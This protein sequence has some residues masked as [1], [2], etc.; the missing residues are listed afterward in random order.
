MSGDF[1]DQMQ[2][3]ASVLSGYV[4][5]YKS[6]EYRYNGYTIRIEGRDLL[7]YYPGDRLEMDEVDQQIRERGKDKQTSVMP[8]TASAMAGLLVVTNPGHGYTQYYLENG[9]TFWAL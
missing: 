8:S 7:D 4:E 9:N 5:K 2:R 3:F 6:G 1:Q